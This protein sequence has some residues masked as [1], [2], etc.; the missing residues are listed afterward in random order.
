MVDRTIVEDALVDG[1]FDWVDEGTLTTIV[2]ESTGVADPSTRDALVF[3]VVAWLLV[4]G[5]MTPTTMGNPWD[6]DIWEAL[7][8]IAGPWFHDSSRE[9]QFTQMELTARGRAAA[10]AIA[11]REGWTPPTAALYN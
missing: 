11:V 2:A 10:E 5:Y 4:E 6:V 3:G 7:R 9:L 1:L 8:R